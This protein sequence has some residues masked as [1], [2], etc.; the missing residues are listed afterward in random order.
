MEDFQK[1]FYSEFINQFEFQ[2]TESQDAV[3]KLFSK[4]V[5]ISEEKKLF[6]LS[7]YAG[8]GKTTLVGNFVQT[9]KYFNRYCTLLAPT[10]RAAK[11]F[12]GFAKQKAFTIHKKIYRK[13][14]LENGSIQL[15]LAPNLSKNTIFIVDE[16]SMIADFSAT[17]NGNISERNLLEDLLE[18]VY[19]GLGCSL[20]FVGDEGQLPPVGSDF[21]PA[22]QKE[23][24]K[25]HFPSLTIDSFKLTEVLRQ[26]ENSDILKNATKIRAYKEGQNIKF[27]Q[28]KKSDVSYINGIEFQEFLEDSYSQNGM[29]ETIVITKSNKRANAYNHEIRRRILY[30]EEEISS[31]DMIM[32]VK[33]NYFWIPETS[34]A[35][36]IANGEILRVKKVSNKEEIHGFSF[37]KLQVEMIDYPEMGTIPVLAILDTLT[38]ETPSLNREE[39]KKLFFSVEEDYLDEKNK[40]KRYE[41]ILADPYFNALQI[42]FA[43]AVTCHKAQ[44]GQWNNV[45]LDHGYLTEDMLDDSF[46]RWLYTGFTRAKEKLYLVNFDERFIKN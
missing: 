22:L 2:V 6:I 20:V 12:S 36:F 16:A 30:Q 43:Y 14:K 23:Y 42:K 8:T 10:G 11:V 15:A 35:G 4:F 38:S 25:N 46:Y 28:N 17:K 1:Q 33:N 26:T 19:S 21:S 24:L 44:G 40:K 27:S 7:G 18:F 13:V 34:E 5:L 41:K 31:N 9:L 39:M 32:V 45:F 3:V 37:I 29:D